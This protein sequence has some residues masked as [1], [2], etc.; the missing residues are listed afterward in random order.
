MHRVH[1]RSLALV[2]F[3]ARRALSAAL[4]VF[5]VASATL[6]LSAAAQG[7]FV[8]AAFGFDVRRDTATRLRAAHGL[9]RPVTTI[10]T[11]W[12]ARAARLDLGHS[13]MYQRPVAPLVAERVANTTVLAAAALVLALSLGIPAGMLSGSRGGLASTCIRAA[14][15]LCLS[16]PPLIAA[17]LLVALAAATG[18]A[19]VGGMTTLSAHPVGWIEWAHDLARH[20]PLP[21]LAL[22]LPFAAM[23]ERVQ[24]Q[25]IAQALAE[26]CMLAA[27]ARGLSARQVL[28]RHA[29]RLGAR[30]VAAVGGLLAGTLLSGSFAVELVTSWPGLGRLTYDALVFRDFYLAAGCAT[31]AALLLAIGVLASDLLVAVVDPRV[32]LAP[33]AAHADRMPS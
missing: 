16:V 32:A 31:A 6:L 7:D 3:L 5:V 26:P 25:A 23:L 14:S 10:Y 13:L 1:G 17:I 11:D 21:A 15:A 8:S 24:A 4:V 18:L 2:R 33:H 30:P 20:V 19:P 28:W 9:D 12:L 29:W 22:A 27:L